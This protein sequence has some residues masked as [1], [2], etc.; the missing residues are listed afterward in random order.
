MGAKTD[1]RPKF[2]SLEFHTRFFPAFLWSRLRPRDRVGTGFPSAVGL[3]VM[4]VVCC[5]LVIL[6]LPGAVSNRS[7]IGWILAGAGAAG[8]LA[9]LINSLCSRREAPSYDGFLSGVFL[10]FVALGI[11]A[12]VFVGTLEHSVP[13]GLLIGLGGLIAGYLLGIMAGLW[14]QYL[15]WLASMVNILAGLAVLGMLCVD[16]VLLGGSL[17]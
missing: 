2:L 1:M 17:F 9:L 8:I 14:F 16:L 12:G 3:Q 6:G 13:M 11:S 15:G 10:F 7:F 4:F 5:I